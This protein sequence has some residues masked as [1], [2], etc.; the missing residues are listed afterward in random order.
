M[1]E[2]KNCLFVRQKTFVT[3]AITK[4]VDAIDI[5]R[6]FYILLSILLT[7]AKEQHKNIN[8]NIC[9]DILEVY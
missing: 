4:N 3:F 2:Q 7:R 6:V 9:L 5:P 8:T 1:R